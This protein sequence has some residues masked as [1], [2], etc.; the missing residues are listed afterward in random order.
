MGQETGPRAEDNPGNRRAPAP[1]RRFEGP[2]SFESIWASVLRTT[3]P[4]SV[5]TLLESD[6]DEILF[7]MRS[8][9]LRTGGFVIVPDGGR[10]EVR[11]DEGLNMRSGSG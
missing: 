5:A 8:R 3:A 10:D 11:Q 2:F 9:F 6:L 7:V 4:G 1:T